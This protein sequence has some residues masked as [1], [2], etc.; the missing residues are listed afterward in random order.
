MKLS[1]TSHFDRKL[2][3]KIHKN[4]KLKKN[5]AKQ[6]KLL[7]KNKRS[8]SLKMHRLKGERALEYSIWIRKNLRITFQIIEDVILLTDII[9]HDEY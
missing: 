1:S 7:V 6:L 9:T 3:R 5:I 2:A 4:P 8:P